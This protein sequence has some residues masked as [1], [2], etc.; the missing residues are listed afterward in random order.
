MT[1]LTST[2][3]PVFTTG[4]PDSSQINEGFSYEVCQ[5]FN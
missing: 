3:T 5:E 4:I 1:T 2:G